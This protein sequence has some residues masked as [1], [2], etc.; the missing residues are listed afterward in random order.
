LF[1]MISAKPSL[2][3]F[4]FLKTARQQRYPRED[5]DKTER[6]VKSLCQEVNGLIRTEMWYEEDVDK[7][8]NEIIRACKR[9]RE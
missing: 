2:A 7:F 6:Y 1:N 9:K 5:V 3:V 4:V 8:Y